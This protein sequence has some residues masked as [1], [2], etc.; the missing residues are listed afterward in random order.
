[1]HVLGRDQ[2]WINLL[3]NEVKTE[4]SEALAALIAVEPMLPEVSTRNAM[5]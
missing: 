4:V 1:M 2:R 5:L 3:S